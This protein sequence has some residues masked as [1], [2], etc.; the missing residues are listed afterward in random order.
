[1]DLKELKAKAI[2]VFEATGSDK[3][4]S[5][6]DGNF[7]LPAAKSLAEDHARK[8]GL[9]VTEILR[10]QKAEEAKEE[11]PDLTEESAEKAA[12]VAQDKPKKTTKKK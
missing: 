6:G 11:V 4:L 10:A 9:K 12:E 1:M 3:L 7:F 8:N 5:T 2:E